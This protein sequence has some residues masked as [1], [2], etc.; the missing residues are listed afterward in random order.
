VLFDPFRFLPFNQPMYECRCPH[1]GK[2][3]AEIARPPLQAMTGGQLC[4]CGRWAIPT[5]ELEF[6]Q[7]IRTVRC[8]CGYQSTGVAGFVVRI[9]CTKCKKIINF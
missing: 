8:P 9:Q 1:D 5:I 4:A 6:D 7:I 3:L 2:M